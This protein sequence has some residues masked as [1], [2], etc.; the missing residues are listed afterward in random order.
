MHTLPYNPMM[1]PELV[2]ERSHFLAVVGHLS[3]DTIVH[4]NFK[5]E[6]SPGGSAAAVATASVQLGIKT[7][8]HSRIG[9]D[10]PREWLRVLEALGVDISNLEFEEKEESLRMK[11][12]YDE[13]GVL[14]SVEFSDGIKDALSI[15]SLPRTECVHICPLQPLN[16]VQLVKSARDECELLSLAFSEFFMDDYRKRDFFDKFE[17]KKIDAVFVNDKVAKAMTKKRTPEK[18][19]SKFHDSG[20]GL[21]SI[22]LGK[23]GT[24]VHDGEHMH[25]INPRDVK[26]VD[27]TGCQE[28]YIGGFLGEYLVSKNAKKAAGMGTYLASLTAQKKGSWAALLSDVGVRF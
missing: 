14:A 23:K 17:W 16:Q 5:I 4:P 18:M 3:I 11:I 26:V 9:N 25:N 24:L 22:S 28:S 10:Y 2:G 1:K 19:T 15:E 21:V 27:P 20:V 8:I 6:A 12:E 7:S 13:N